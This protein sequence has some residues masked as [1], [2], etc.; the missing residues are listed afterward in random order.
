MA[1]YSVRQNDTEIMTCAVSDI[2]K[3]AETKTNS[4]HVSSIAYLQKGDVLSI[5]NHHNAGCITHPDKVFYGAF[6]IAEI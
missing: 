5:K 4:C 6:K 1:G 2:T 3:S